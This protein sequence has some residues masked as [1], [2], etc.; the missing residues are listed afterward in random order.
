M[1]DSPNDLPKPPRTTAARPF[2]S[3]RPSS[4]ESGA[5]PLDLSRRRS[6]HLFTPPGSAPAARIAD[7]IPSPEA[8]AEREPPEMPTSSAADGSTEMEADTS[9]AA[10]GPDVDFEGDWTPAPLVERELDAESVQAHADAASDEDLV[11]EQFEPAEIELTASDSNEH[12]I[13]VIE[14]NSANMRLTAAANEGEDPEIDGIYLESTEFS[15]E[16][17]APRQRGNADNFWAP[18]PAKPVEGDAR[19]AEQQPV[20]DETEASIDEQTAGE[21]DPEHELAMK[22]IGTE[23]SIDEQPVEWADD[24]STMIAHAQSAAEPEPEHEPAPPSVVQSTP[25]M[26]TP[27]WMS[28]VTPASTQSLEELKESE[29]WTLTPPQGQAQIVEPVAA[30]PTSHDVADALERIAA[31]VRDGRIDVPTGSDMS[32]ETALSTVLTA[33]L[34]SRR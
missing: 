25:S 32:D 24:P 17:S 2:L 31:R 7:R 12:A 1:E 33:L 8:P 13:E 30:A 28:L 3:P 34:R 4:S 14:Y 21:V 9:Q 10:A 16:H 15:F 29:P 22:M 6:V 27:A 11:I 26:I 20:A 18:A 23:P 19:T 5:A